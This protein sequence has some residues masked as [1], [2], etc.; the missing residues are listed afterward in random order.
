MRHETF[1]NTIFQCG[2]GG[3][4]IPWSGYF[5]ITLPD[6]LSKFPLILSLPECIAANPASKLK[7]IYLAEKSAH[8][9]LKFSLKDTSGNVL[10]R[11][12]N[13]DVLVPRPVDQLNCSHEKFIENP[14]VKGCT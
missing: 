3:G 1:R 12:P 5:K 7:I 6:Y 4:N 11:K 14:D 10:I 9:R 13:L 2:S 8:Y